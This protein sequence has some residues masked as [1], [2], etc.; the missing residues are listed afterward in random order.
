[1]IHNCSQTVQFHF[2]TLHNNHTYPVNRTS[3]GNCYVPQYIFFKSQ[4]IKVKTQN[5]TY[6][7]IWHRTAMKYQKNV[8][9]CQ[10]L[11]MSITPYWC[12]SLSKVS[13]QIKKHKTLLGKYKT[14]LGNKNPRISEMASIHY[15][16]SKKANQRLQAEK[17]TDVCSCLKLK[18]DR[19]WQ[20]SYKVAGKIT[21]SLEKTSPR[22]H[23]TNVL[24]LC[25]FHIVGHLFYHFLTAHCPLWH[26]SD[27][28]THFKWHHTLTKAV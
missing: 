25:F 15:R 6:T 21:R 19:L 14:P 22:G 17:H 8:C 3:C 1:M 23:C 26:V 4:E 12:V 7:I 27:F 5:L 28:N 24:F 16:D 18:G 9:L 20:Q 11:N 13:T 10:D 2:I